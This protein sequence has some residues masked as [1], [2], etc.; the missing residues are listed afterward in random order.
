MARRLALGQEGL[1]L[2]R[3]IKTFKQEDMD[4]WT[5]EAAEKWRPE[6]HGHREPTI[7]RA[8]KAVRQSKAQA[9]RATESLDPEAALRNSPLD[10]EQEA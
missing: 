5:P 2:R 6:E 1:E 7:K 8:K 3:R 10:D 9:Q 4:I